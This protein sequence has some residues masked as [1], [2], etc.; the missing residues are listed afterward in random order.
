[1]KC[2]FRHLPNYAVLAVQFDLAGVFTADSFISIH[3]QRLDICGIFDLKCV[4]IMQKNTVEVNKKRKN[5]YLTMP[6]STHP[7]DK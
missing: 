4:E 5:S 6:K 7:A 3:H 1:M 2:C